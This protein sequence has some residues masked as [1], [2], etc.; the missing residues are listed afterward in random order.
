M[1]YERNVIG[2]AE[3]P[4][5]RSEA[6]GIVWRPTGRAQ[7]TPS[8]VNVTAALG[9]QR[10]R[11][12]ARRVSSDEHLTITRMAITALAD[13]LPARATCAAR[14]GRLSRESGWA[15]TA[16]PI[17]PR[18]RRIGDRPVRGNPVAQNQRV[19]A[20]RLPRR[21]TSSAD[22]RRWASVYRSCASAGSPVGSGAGRIVSPAV[23]G[24]A[25]AREAFSAP[26]S[27]DWKFLP[28]PSYPARTAWC[29]GPRSRAPS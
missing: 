26:L 27:P 8:A 9:A 16:G 17:R 25:T 6:S 19:L 23:Q 1:A 12:R 14:R 18:R 4:Q 29:R 5:A 2:V 24:D 3:R 7:R 11:Q 13:C 10:V 21:R 22:S 20:R 15:V 28:Q